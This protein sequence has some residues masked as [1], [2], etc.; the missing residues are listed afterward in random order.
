M[1]S[2]PVKFPSLAKSKT[3]KLRQGANTNGDNFDGNGT[4]FPEM[5][6][7]SVILELSNNHMIQVKFSSDGL[8]RLWN[9]LDFLIVWNSSCWEVLPA[10][11]AV[12]D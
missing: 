4:K 8:K 6:A 1:K 2:T 5:W 9:S 3:S 11:P 7:I 10:R 12:F